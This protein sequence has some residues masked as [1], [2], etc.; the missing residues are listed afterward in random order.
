MKRLGA[1]APLLVGNFPG[2]TLNVPPVGSRLRRS[3]SRIRESFFE[4]LIRAAR[5]G[6]VPHRQRLACIG[7][8]MAK[9]CA[10]FEV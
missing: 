6:Q 1:T 8:E 4:F 3:R 2:A 7:E 9:F 10:G 5:D